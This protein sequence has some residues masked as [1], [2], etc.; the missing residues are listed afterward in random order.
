MRDY[1]FQELNEIVVE[2]FGNYRRDARKI[3]ENN[4]QALSRFFVDYECVIKEGACEAAII[5]STLC[6]ELE[7]VQQKT[8]SKGHYERISKVLNGYD[9]KNIIGAIEENEIIILSNQVKQ[10]IEIIN[11]M[12]LV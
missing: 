4:M 3:S 2:V 5:C 12:E 8:I 11:A 9:E 10:A 1:E 6:I 7:K